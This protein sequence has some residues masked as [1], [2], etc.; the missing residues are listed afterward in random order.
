[1]EESPTRVG[2]SCALQGCLIGSV[3]LFVIL[4]LVMLFLAFQR[5]REET[6]AGSGE[7]AAMVQPVRL[8]ALAGPVA[9]IA[10]RFPRES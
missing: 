6:G 10:P 5:F 3:A 7:S 4:L 2:S 9:H 8:I 1:M